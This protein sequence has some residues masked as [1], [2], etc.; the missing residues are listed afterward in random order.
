MSER[1]VTPEQVQKEHL[2]EVNVPAQWL[3]LFGVLL[4][5]VVLMVG[6]IGLLDAMG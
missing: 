1:D 3:Y 4:V 2:D 6:L 5:G